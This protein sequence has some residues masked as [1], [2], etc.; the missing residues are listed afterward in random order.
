MCYVK[1]KQSA[2][3]SVPPAA[4][5]SAPVKDE[6][7]ASIL[8]STTPSDWMG[9]L[10]MDTSSI[11]PLDFLPPLEF[12]ASA[13]SGLPMDSDWMTWLEGMSSFPAMP[14]APS[15]LVAPTSTTLSPT[16]S[17]HSTMF[18]SDSEFIPSPTM[19]KECSK[20]RRAPVQELDEAATKRAR[21]TEAA[22]K[23]RARKAAKVEDLE[24]KVDVLESDK[25]V[26]TVRIAVLE[27][28]AAS[29]N[30]R[31]QDLKRRVALLELQLAESHRALLAQ[32]QL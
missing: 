24:H 19:E 27:N 16:L 5:S 18:A 2:P 31:E 6:T 15:S 7:F 28:D 11:S 4:S 26:L 10:S 12:D 3:A 8:G 25:S 22:R 17:T 21:N 20:K 23:S 14:S 9:A 13:A 30:Q 32:Q 29:F 1:V